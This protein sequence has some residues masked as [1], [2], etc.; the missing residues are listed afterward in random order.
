MGI[1]FASLL[2]QIIANKNKKINPKNKKGGTF[3]FFARHYNKSR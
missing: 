3:F 1:S 2:N